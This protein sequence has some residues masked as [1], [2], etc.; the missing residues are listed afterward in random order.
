MMRILVFQHVPV[1][2]PGVF[3]DFWSES[4][5]HWDAVE[6][7]AG[8][9]IPDLRRY[10]LLVAMGG[11]M[12]VW[13]EDAHPWLRSEKEAIR[14]WVTDLGRPFLGICLGHQLLAEALGGTVSP[15]ARPEVGIAEVELT[16]LGQ[17]D[18]IFAGFAAR[19]ET[20]QWH[21]AEISRI[22]NGAEVLA[23]NAASPVQAMR[24][25]RHAYGFQY[26]MEI[27]GETV[28]DWELIPAYKT[29]L[30]LALGIEEA[31]RLDENV[32]PRLSAFRQAARRLNRNLSTIISNTSVPVSN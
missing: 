20:F 12:D 9:S 7:D 3:R 27:T 2:H 23:S 4:G 30:E 22:P 1:E 18:P 25:G 16:P 29:S 31:S 26:H 21:G 11:P 14:E 5:H 24:W 19:V 13:E 10:D 8:E 32:A 17:R 15:M 6:L 28:T